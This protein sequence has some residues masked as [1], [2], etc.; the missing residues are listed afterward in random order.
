MPFELEIIKTKSKDYPPTLKEDKKLRVLFPQLWSIGSLDILKRPLLGLFCSVKCPGDLIIKTYDLAR[1]LRDNKITVI[2]GFHSP[3]EKDCL[4]FLI[5][6][7]QTIVLCP[8]R[9]I[10]SMR[11][12]KKIRGPIDEGRLLILSPFEENI[13]RHTQKTS[14]LRNQFVSSLA[15]ALFIAHAEI[16]G[17]IEEMCKDILL[18]NKPVYTFE[19]KYNESLAEMGAQPVNIE[20]LNDWS[21]FIKRKNISSIDN[22]L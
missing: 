6:G 15:N 3:I 11:M 12:N 18:Q 20:N 17:K 16:G 7:D 8:A 2:S 10:K 5:K 13:K 22:L 9:S 21:I 19:S 1:S 14:Q 4:D